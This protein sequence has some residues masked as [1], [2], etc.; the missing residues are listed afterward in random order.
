MNQFLLRVR[1]AIAAFLTTMLA[2][3]AVFPTLSHATDLVG[4]TA[5]ELGVSP[6][7]SASY[8]IP[9]AVPVGTTGLQPKIT[10]QYDSL[11]G[12]GVAGMGWTVGGLAVIGRCPTS[13][14]MDGTA[15]GSPGLDPVDYDAND[16]FC[17]NGQRLVPVSGTYGAPNTEYRTTQEEFSKIVSY[18]TAGSGPQYFKVWRKSGEILEFGNT[19]DS[20]IEALGRADVWVWALN[21]LSDTAGNYETFTYTE[22]TTDGGFRISRVDYTGNAAQGLSPYNHM[23]F[24]YAARL[25]V[26]S[27]YQAGSRITQNQRL[28][29]IKVYADAAL[30][31]DY[32]VTYETTPGL[33]GRSRPTGIKECAP[34]AM[35]GSDCF[36]PT[37]FQWSPDGAAT[38]TTLGLTGSQGIPVSPSWSDYNVLAS[39]DFNG[40]G[41]TDMY[42]VKTN[43][44]GQASGSATL[45]DRVLLADG[46]GGFQTITV[47]AA[48]SLVQNFAVAGTGDFNGDGLTDFYAFEIDGDGRKNGTSLDKTYFSNGDGTFSIVTLSAATSARDED[49]IRKPM[50]IRACARMS[51]TSAAWALPR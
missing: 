48:S 20:R 46:T 32:Q 36:P 17:L 22:D 31:R 45:T 4:A 34:N 15:A 40:D 39:G 1:A 27:T 2:L 11:A 41:R 24:I 29:N 28:T 12:N 3:A 33:S 23:D 25:D 44:S 8:T 49:R 42:L 37:T 38:L 35:G 21:K 30:F 26:S 47:P 13:Y 14:S 10:L 18:G 19:A 50:P 9:V 5:G 43:A 16:K 51:M 6:S 7:G